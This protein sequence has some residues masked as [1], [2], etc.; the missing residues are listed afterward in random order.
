MIRTREEWLEYCMSRGTSGDQVFNILADWAEYERSVMLHIT[1]ITGFTADNS[2]VDSFEHG[3]AS[4]S[5]SSRN[6]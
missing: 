5:R 2:G 6:K 1:G 4:A 3:I